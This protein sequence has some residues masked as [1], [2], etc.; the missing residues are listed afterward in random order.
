MFSIQQSVI[1][2]FLFSGF[3]V[4][5]GGK[6]GGAMFMIGGIILLVL[7]AGI[8]TRA[9]LNSYGYWRS[10]VDDDQISTDIQ[11]AFIYLLAIMLLPGLIFILIP[12]V[13][14]IIL[15]LLIQRAR[16]ENMA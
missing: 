6:A 9:T 5:F 14:N 8:A 1:G 15:A 7:G 12:L 3:G 13:F 16:H 2:A 11:I 10:A 4:L